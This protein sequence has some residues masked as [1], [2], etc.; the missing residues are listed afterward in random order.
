MENKIINTFSYCLICGTKLEFKI[1][2]VIIIEL[3][4]M[5]WFLLVSWSHEFNGGL[6]SLI[7]LGGP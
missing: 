3:L 6:S 2:K 5:E 1:S 7:W 4:K